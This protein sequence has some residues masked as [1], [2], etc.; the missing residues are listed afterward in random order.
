MIMQS[1]MVIRCWARLHR[2][3]WKSLRSL[4]AVCLLMLPAMAAFSQAAAPAVSCESL[5][6]LALPDTTITMAQPVAAGEF[7][8]P[9]RGGGPA[10]QP[11]AAGAA[12]QQPAGRAAASQGSNP[13]FCRVAA[14]LKPSIDSNIKVEVWLPLS[15][16]NRKFVAAGNGGWAGSISYNGML[17]ALQSGYATAATDTGH[18]SSQPGQNGGEFIIGHPEK[19]IDYA[20]RADHLMTVTA[21]AIIS[22]FYGSSPEHSYW[23]GC[24]LGGLEGLIEAKRFPEDFDGIVV[25]SP[26]NPL[27]TFNAAQIWPAWLISKDPSRFIPPSKLPMI[28]EAALKACASPIGLKQGFIEEPDRCN[29]DPRALLCK[30]QDAPDCLTAHQVDLMRQVYAGPVNPRTHESIFPGLSPGAELQLP[31]YSQQTEAYSTAL[32]LFKYAAFHNADW[33]WRTFDFDKVLAAAQREVD[34]ILNVDANLNAFLDRGGKLM[35]YIG[36]TEYKN[37]THMRDYYQN[38]LKNAGAG[39]DNSVR[40]FLL[41]GMDHC[42]GGAGCDQ[43]DKMGSIDEWVQH[44]RAPERIVSSK[45]SGGKVVRTRP[46]CAYPLVAKYKGTGSIDEAESFVC[47]K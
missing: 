8:M 1:N 21:K 23:V 44:G 17:P 6:K 26:P 34:P 16:W 35:M 25:G 38:V 5:A 39:K 42:G 9:P 33:D 2:V 7:K 14:N 45:L 18:D 11:G 10:G 19:L 30:G 29:F 13:A 36:G 31:K 15:G 46:I 32:D 28:H 41:P 37:F 4:T 27:T 24:S 20:Y 47:S 3:P 22:A 43:F 40:L 12:A